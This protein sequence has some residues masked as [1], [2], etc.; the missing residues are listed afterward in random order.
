MRISDW[1]S[2][3]CSSDLHGIAV[4]A[5]GMMLTTDDGGAHWSES[6]PML[7]DIALHL[8]AIVRAG[9]GSL[10]IAG[11]RGLL[12]HSSDGGLSW[13]LLQSP[14][15]GSWFRALTYGHKG[16]LLYS[17]EERRVGRRVV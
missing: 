15:V 16:E 11:E 9:D 3:V 1:S 17:S 14:Y 5:Y 13:R 8:N 10:L 2:D 12:A 4:G 7:A 6:A